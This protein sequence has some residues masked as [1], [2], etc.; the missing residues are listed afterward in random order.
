M[1]CSSPRASIGLSMLPASIEPSALPAPTMVWIS[2]MKRMSCPADFTT[3]ASTALSRSSNSPRNFAPA[4]SALR[5]SAMIFLSRKL[6]GTSCATMR[7]ARPSTIAVLPTPGSPMSTG[8]FFVRREST[9]MVRRISVVAADDRVELVLAGERGQ[10][11]AIFLQRL[12]G[13]LG[14]LA[15]H[16]LVAAHLLHRAE[17]GVAREAEVA[18]GFSPTSVSRFS[19]NIASIRCSTETYSS[20]SFFASSCARMS[21]WLSRCVMPA[22]P[23][24]PAPVTFGMRSSA[25][26]VRLSARSSETLSRSSRR[27]MSPFSCVMSA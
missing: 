20:L 23:C 22:C 26:C 5:S 15:G 13:R 25:A 27:G 19:S 9:W 11:A 8:L 3:S 24:A 1:Q 18:S 16:A 4:M 6:S 10:V 7:W 21:S 17:E 14:I 12:V 2:S